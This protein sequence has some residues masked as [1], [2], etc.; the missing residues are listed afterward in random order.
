MKRL[1]PLVLL[2]LFGCGLLP[3]PVPAPT[4]VPSP[5]LAPTT[6]SPQAPLG[7]VKNP[8]ILALAPSAR[9]GQDVL[10]AGNQLEADLEKATGFTIVTVIPPDETQLVQAFEIG[11]AH[12][13]VLSP[14]AY[15]LASQDGSVEAAFARQ[16]DGASFY[17][18]QFIVRSDSGFVPYYDP[19]KNENTVE[20]GSALAQFRDKKPCWTDQRSP[21]GYVVP[22]GYLNESGVPTRAPA[23]LAGHPTVVRAVY[24]GGICDF[25]ATYIDARSYPGLQD[26]Y[27]DVMK[28]VLVV[29]RIPPIIPYETLVFA[30]GMSIDMQRALTRAFV[31]LM[32]SSDGNKIMQTLYGMDAM[33]VVQDSQ[34]D[35]FRKV[36]Q[37]S[38]LDL[39]GLLK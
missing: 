35:A 24:S 12:I 10:D 9:P 22:L 21:S 30:R 13:G 4:P 6:A 38:G 27:P 28:K 18:S 25:G 31:D 26:G 2:G 36:V 14:F 16:L 11:N 17:G 7:T 32:S 34:Y 1:L 37:A 39:T 5:T 23:F 19:L 3:R 33:Q 8:L 15:L 20:A 29:W